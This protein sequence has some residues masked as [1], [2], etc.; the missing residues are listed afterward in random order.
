MGKKQGREL[1][2]TRL[3]ADFSDG[4][5]EGW[6]MAVPRGFREALDI[7]LTVRK[8]KEKNVKLWTQGRSF[9][10]QHGDTLYDTPDAYLVWEKALKVLTL[11]VAVEEARPAEYSPSGSDDGYIRFRVYRPNK[12]RTRIEPAEEIESTQTAFVEF[13]QTGAIQSETGELTNLLM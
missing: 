13:L 2:N 4:F 1:R 6:A 7:Q 9:N 5:A 8:V 12:A 11:A 10:F 3:I